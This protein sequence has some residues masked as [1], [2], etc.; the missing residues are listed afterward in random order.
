MKEKIELIFLSILIL[1]GL[2]MAII[3]I[4]NGWWRHIVFGGVV[5]LCATAAFYYLLMKTAGWD[6]SK[7]EKFTKESP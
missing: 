1:G 6:N 3:G 4:V 5:Y 7:T 2:I